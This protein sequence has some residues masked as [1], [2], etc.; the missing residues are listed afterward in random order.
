MVAY[1]GVGIL[2]GAGILRVGLAVAPDFISNSFIGTPFQAASIVFFNT[3]TS[4]LLTGTAL[5]LIV[6]IVMVVSGWLFSG[7]K[8]AVALRAKAETLRTDSSKST[9]PPPAPPAPPAAQAPEHPRQ[10]GRGLPVVRTADARL[11]AV[12][13]A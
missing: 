12:L 8:H 1:V 3:L 6:G 5:F 11:R 4:C 13:V 10:F 7:Q 2:L 9:P